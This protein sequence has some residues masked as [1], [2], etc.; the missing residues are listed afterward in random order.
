[1]AFFGFSIEVFIINLVLVIPT[2]FLIRWLTNKI[3]KSNNKLRNIVPWIG[4]IV[5]V[6]II[7]FSFVFIW[8]FSISYYPDRTFDKT[9]WEQKP[10]ERYE[11]TEDIIESELLIGLN[12]DEVTE[13]LGNYDYTY[14]ENHWAY[15][16]GFV[17]GIM[18]IDPSVLD[19]YFENER[20]I[21][22]SQHET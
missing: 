9:T 22:V 1:M 7:Y 18:N 10:Y 2:F 21:K 13:L 14:D 16:I 3:F 6:P 8:I 12:K 5:L 4:T 11:L 17:P 20:V 19:I 15:G